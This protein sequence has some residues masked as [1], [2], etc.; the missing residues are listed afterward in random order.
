MSGTS[1]LAERPIE[2]LTTETEDGGLLFHHKE[3]L[4]PDP[5]FEVATSLVLIL[6]VSHQL[7]IP[8]DARLESV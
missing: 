7:Q 5:R 3:P 2:G 1:I 4:K 8:M 6:Q